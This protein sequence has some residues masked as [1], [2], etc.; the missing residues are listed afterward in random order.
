M[1]GH[2]NSVYKVG[3]LSSFLWIKTEVQLRKRI[4]G[5]G[6][7]PQLIQW[8]RPMVGAHRFG[9]T[10]RCLGAQCMSCNSN[11]P[12]WKYTYEKPNNVQKRV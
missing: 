4:S 11:R 6:R 8:A 10:S 2:G 5:I 3:I 7:G 9:T 1:H 12:R